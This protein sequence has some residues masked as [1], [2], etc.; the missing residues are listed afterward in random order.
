MASSRTQIHVIRDLEAYAGDPVIRPHAIRIWEWGSQ[1]PDK[2]VR[3]Y[4]ETAL[5]EYR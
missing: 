4:A 1:S 2:E 5:K 3:A